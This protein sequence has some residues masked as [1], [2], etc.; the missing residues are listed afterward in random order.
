MTGSL[1]PALFA[2]LAAVVATSGANAQSL[3]GP[4][5][6]RELSGH[7]LTGYNG[8]LWFS[9]YHAPDG[10][11]LGHNGGV[12][13]QGACWKVRGD[14]VCYYYPRDRQNEHDGTLEFC[15]RL[16]RAGQESYRIVSVDSG[17]SGI[18]RLESGNARNH[19]DDD[20]PWTCDAQV[21]QHQP[22]RPGPYCAAAAK[23]ASSAVPPFGKD[24][25]AR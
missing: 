16:S 8:N 3:S 2:A 24:H 15:W 5:L 22:P 20:R 18:A 6:V 14:A 7:T 1:A 12:K 10:R 4:E 25:A 17:A 9:E 21:S 11:V 13:N 19:T 23:L